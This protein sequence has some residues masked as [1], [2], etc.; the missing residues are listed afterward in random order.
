MTTS[1]TPGVDGWTLLAAGGGPADPVT[2]ALVAAGEEP[3]E[4]RLMRAGRE[5]ALH[6]SCTRTGAGLI[7][8]VTA[9]LAD[10]A[11]GASVAATV[12]RL[13]TPVRAL[14]RMDPYGRIRLR[15]ALA[16]LL[17]AAAPDGASAVS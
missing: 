1:D 2:A 13:L 12:V 11:T 17:G 6:L 16:G 15:R 3:A 4:V 7:T 8:A 14:S 10:L 9:D 5:Y